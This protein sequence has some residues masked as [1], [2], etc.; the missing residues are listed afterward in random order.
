MTKLVFLFLITLLS[1]QSSPACNEERMQK[2][3]HKVGFVVVAEVVE[4]KPA[5][6]FWSG[7]LAAVQYVRYKVI[8]SLKGKTAREIEVGHYVVKN[9]LTAAK[10]Q[11]RLSPELFKVG[12]R[13]ILFIQL[14]QRNQKAEPGNLTFLSQ[15]ENC[16][17]VLATHHSVQVVRRV[18]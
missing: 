13:L 12:N 14:D 10:D 17:A 8:E 5:P 1:M 18:L 15:D 7:Q 16:G 6:G 3:A 4:V 11:A 9:S 2:L